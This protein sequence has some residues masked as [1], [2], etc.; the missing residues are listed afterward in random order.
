MLMKRLFDVVLAILLLMI[1]LLLMV[2]VWLLSAI[3]TKSNGLFFQKRIGQ[4]GKTFTIIKFRTMRSIALRDP[5]SGEY[6]NRAIIPP[7]CAALRKYKLDELPQL[8]N[9]ISGDMSFV[10]PR[11]DL[12][13]Y[14]DQ[15]E[16]EERKILQLKP[17][18]TCEASIKYA[19]E[20][21]LLKKQKNPEQYNDEVIFPDK[22]KMNLEYYYK[23]SFFGDIKI[24][25]N[26]LFR[27]C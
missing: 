25:F 2:V 18:V 12:P 24:L 10:G 7:V 6:V 20:E 9:I 22:V 11:P 19:D 3:A 17:G 16:G 8:I 27:F 23:R 15:L 4:F 13:G 26:T 21:N 5:V 1:G 14:Y